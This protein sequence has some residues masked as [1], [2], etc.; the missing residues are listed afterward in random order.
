VQEFYRRIT[1][2]AQA[3]GL[4]YEL[5]LVN[6]GSPDDSLNLALELQQTDPRV[7]VVDLSRNF[8]HHKAIKAGLRQARGE[9]VFLID[10]DLEEAPELLTRFWDH[11]QTLQDTDVLYGVQKERKGGFFERISGKIFYAVLNFLISEVTYPANPLTARLMSRR[12]VDRVLEFDEREYDLWFS[13]ALTGFRQ[14]ALEADKGNKGSSAYTLRRKLKLASETITATSSKPLVLI[15][16]LGIAI[17]GLSF[18][19][20]AYLLVNKLFFDVLIGWTSILGSIWLIG[21]LLML[22]IGVIG[23]YLSKIFI[24]TKKRPEY[25]IKEVYWHVG[26]P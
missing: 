13:F 26:E 22:S 19:Y 23:I 6:D 7:V 24:E 2:S 17:S 4:D 1:A 21:G 9:L 16:G 20:L 8:G 5:I 11:W 12:Y 25:I 3:T 18:C 14:A 15:F 10:C